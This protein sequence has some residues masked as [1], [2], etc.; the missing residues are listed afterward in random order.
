MSAVTLAPGRN[1]GEGARISGYASVFGIPDEAHD[2]VVRGAFRFRDI[3]AALAGTVT[4]A[5]WSLLR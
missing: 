5:H 4:R 1:P 3:V 2:V